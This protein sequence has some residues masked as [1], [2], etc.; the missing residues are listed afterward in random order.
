MQQLAVVKG[1]EY[2]GLLKTHT[3]LLLFI[4]YFP[5]VPQY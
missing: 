2:K 3:V 1:I 4:H 5:C